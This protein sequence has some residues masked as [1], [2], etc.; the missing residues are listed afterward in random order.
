M[1]CN[2][3][4][5]GLWQWMRCFK[6]NHNFMSLLNKHFITMLFKLIK[7]QINFWRVF[8]HVFNTFLWQDS[9]DQRLKTGNEKQKVSTSKELWCWWKKSWDVIKGWRH[10][11]YR[12]N[13]YHFA[14][15]RSPDNKFKTCGIFKESSMFRTSFSCYNE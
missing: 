9:S 6:E 2:N 8:C 10:F 15:A 14:Y 4:L 13:V 1:Q 7:I 3:L 11:F 12:L 5:V